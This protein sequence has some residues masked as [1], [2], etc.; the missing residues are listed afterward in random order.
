MVVGGFLRLNPAETRPRET[1]ILTRMTE[2]CAECGFEYRPAEAA[3]AGPEIVAGAGEVAALLRGQDGSA[4]RRYPDRWSPLEYG[5]H[6][7]DVLLV[8]R[9]RVILARWQETPTL[10]PMARDLRVEYDGYADQETSAVA[11]QLEDAARLFANLLARL[12]EAAWNRTLIYNFPQPTER[13]LRWVAVH[14]LH[15]VV[16]HRL[17]VRRELDADA[18]FDVD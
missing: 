4:R 2:R 6:L 15:E 10:A 18:D 11:R 13:D 16:H 9:E 3:Q 12:D 7:R 8:Q 5:C 17:D 1:A 14:T